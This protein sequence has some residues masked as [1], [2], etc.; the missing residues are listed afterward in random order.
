MFIF[1]HQGSR[2]HESV[3]ISALNRCS[4]WLLAA[5]C[6]KV[7]F[8]DSIW[9][10]NN[11]SKRENKNT[12]SKYGISTT[13]ALANGFLPLLRYPNHKK[14]KGFIAFGVVISTPKRESDSAK[15]ISSE[16]VIRIY[17]SKQKSN[18][19]LIFF[20]ENAK[21]MIFGLILEWE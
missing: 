5:K 8:V 19:P 13:Y 7:P 15:N 20:C 6:R 21:K 2:S 11:Q 4:R 14:R 12:Q 16:T 10:G 3:T 18:Y 1:C 9:S 17:D